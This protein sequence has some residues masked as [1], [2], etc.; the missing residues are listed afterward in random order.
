MHKNVG[1][2]EKSAHRRGKP[3]YGRGIAK[4]K[5]QPSTMFRVRT[6]PLLQGIFSPRDTDH[7]SP[8]IGKCRRSLLPETGARTG[9]AGNAA[10]QRKQHGRT[11]HRSSAT[12]PL[13]P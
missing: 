11:L 1:R 6:G 2:A 5:W 8:G 3:L 4:I 13:Q 7:R 10:G 9:D 12:L